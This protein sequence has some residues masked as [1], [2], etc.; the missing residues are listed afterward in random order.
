VN[1]RNPGT[2]RPPHN[3][4]SQSAGVHERT[5]LIIRDKQLDSPELVFRLRPPPFHRRDDAAARISDEV[6][7]R[8][9]RFFTKRE[10]EVLPMVGYSWSFGRL[11]RI[12][13]VLDPR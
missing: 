13:T 11:G 6:F 1:E 12:S 8:A 7:D 3:P 10:L 5:R 2:P 9:R 4:L